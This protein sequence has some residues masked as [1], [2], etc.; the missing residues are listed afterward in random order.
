M[1]YSTL[2]IPITLAKAIVFPTPIPFIFRSIIG[3]NLRKLVC[4][5]KN[6]ECKNCLY[7]ENC[8]YATAFDE[9]DVHPTILNAEPF[10]SEEKIE[11]IKLSITFLG[12]FSKYDDYYLQ[13]LR[14]GEKFGVL[15]ERISY[16]IENGEIKIENN[17]WK[18][19]FDEQSFATSKQTFKVAFKTPLRFKT[20]GKYNLQFTE[21]DFILCLHRRCQKICS[22]YGA[23]DS[24]K[25]Y[26][27][28]GK[29]K[30]IER[31][32]KWVNIERW[33]SRQKQTMPLGGI[34]GDIVLSGEF[35]E[36]ELALFQFAEL[37]NAGKNTNFGMGKSKLLPFFP[38]LP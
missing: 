1:Q 16:L 6:T 24:S 7:K 28:D 13:A 8:V 31:N 19:N 9:A 34:V 22:L 29:W 2:T 30:I 3:F 14:R 17:E 25:E 38:S 10:L 15:K 32:L 21:L 36:Y 26:K 4:I 5:S 35:S 27:F 37:F 33:S 18:F 23:S 20:Q 12:K 11:K